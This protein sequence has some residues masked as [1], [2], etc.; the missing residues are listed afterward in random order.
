MACCITPNG[1]AFEVAVSAQFG[2]EKGFLIG[3]VDVETADTGPK[4]D[5][6]EIALK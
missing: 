3:S 5:A 1:D 6:E 2:L 4:S